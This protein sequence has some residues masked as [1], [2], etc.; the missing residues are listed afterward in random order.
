MSVVRRSIMRRSTGSYLIRCLLPALGLAIAPAVAPADLI[1]HWKFDDAAPGNTTTTTAA[2]SSPNGNGATYAG[3]GAISW[4]TGKA[5]S[6]F[7]LGGGSSRFELADSSDLKVTGAVTVSAWVKPT[8][9]SNFGLVAGIDQTGGSANDM[10]TLKTSGSATSSPRW[11]VVAAAGTGSNVSLDA[12][13]SLTNFSAATAD[14]W[15]HLAGVFDPGNFARLYVNGVLE[16]E[17]TSAIPTAIQLTVTPFQIGHNASD[18]GSNALQA[19]VDD[20]QVYDQALSAADVALLFNNPGVVIPE[21]STVV[22]A[23]I[24]LLGLVGCGWRRRRK[25]A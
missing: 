7:Q 20:I 18:S 11:D 6:A 19:A 9:T 22:L 4:I 16:A 14:G 13:D 17:D 10:Y 24:G 3:N 12:S 15:V 25:A 2:D 23:A 1:G 8:A 21:P 5:G